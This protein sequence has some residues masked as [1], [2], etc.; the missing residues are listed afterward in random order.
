MMREAARSMFEGEIAPILAAHDGNASLPKPAMLKIF[1]ARA[2]LGI[3]AP[4]IPEADGGG[5]LS[6]LSYGLMFEQLPRGEG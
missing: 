5:G 2:K 4:R 6:M 1:G 3:I